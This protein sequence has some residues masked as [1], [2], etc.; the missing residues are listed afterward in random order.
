[1]GKAKVWFA[2]LGS[3][4]SL[5]VWTGSACLGFSPPEALAGLS[6][7]KMASLCFC[8]LCWMGKLQGLFVF[9]NSAYIKSILLFE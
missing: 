3:N 5:I 4:M 9:V 7:P 6:R 2:L 1:V 8:G